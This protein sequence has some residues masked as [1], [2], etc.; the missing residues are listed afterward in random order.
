M[1]IRRHGPR[2][3]AEPGLL[4]RRGPGEVQATLSERSL[5]SGDVDRLAAAAAQP[6]MREGL[7]RGHAAARADHEKPLHEL[8]GFGGNVAP[9]G[10]PH[11][12]LSLPNLAPELGIPL[13][14]WHAPAEHRESNDAETPHVASA[15]PI[16]LREYLGGYIGEGAGAI[17]HLLPTGH[18]KEAAEPEV[19]ELHEPRVFP[20]VEEVLQFQVS[21]HDSLTMEVRYSRHHLPHDIRRLTFRK[22]P[23]SVKPLQDLT[24]GETLHH[25]VHVAVGLVDC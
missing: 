7:L 15:A 3:C 20:L 5:H 8:L 23:F 12:V 2:Q 22:T 17:A 10:R 16:A 19:D 24:A 1:V 18:V 25:E 4:H 21:V 11:A 13:V 6:R 14:E 9:L